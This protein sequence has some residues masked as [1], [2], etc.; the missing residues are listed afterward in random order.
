MVKHLYDFID[1]ETGLEGSTH[2][3]TSHQLHEGN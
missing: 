1:G 3:A 2:W